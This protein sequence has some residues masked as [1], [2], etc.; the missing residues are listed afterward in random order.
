LR[1]EGGVVYKEVFLNPVD[2]RYMTGGSRGGANEVTNGEGSLIGC[3]LEEGLSMADCW[4]AR[5]RQGFLIG[6][7]DSMRYLIDRYNG[8]C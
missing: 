2:G 7:L 3:R 5:K 8:D 1:P 6:P 4:Y